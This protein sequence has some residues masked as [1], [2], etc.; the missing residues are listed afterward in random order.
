MAKYL[1]L[2]PLL[3]NITAM[4]LAIYALLNFLSAVLIFF[5]Q[6]LAAK[7]IL[8]VLGGAPFVWTGCMVFFQSILLAG[9]I[10]AH[11]LNTYAKKR[12]I[13]YVHLGLFLAAIL[14]YMPLDIKNLVMGAS[15]GSPGQLQW[16]L[17]SLLVTL[18]LPFFIISATSPLTQAWFAQTKSQWQQKPY[19]LYAASNFGS[20]I[21]LFAY[22]LLFEPFLDS[23]AQ[24]AFVDFC[25]V[26]LFVLLVTAGVTLLKS[27]TIKSKKQKAAKPIALNTKL[28]W[29]FY[30][31]IPAGLLYSVSTYI[32]TDLISMPLLWVIPLAIYILTFVLVFGEKARVIG[33]SRVIHFG[34]AAMMVLVSQT[35]VQ[36]L[37]LMLGMHFV[38]LFIFCMACHQKLYDIR[39]KNS[40]QL[41]IFYIFLS[42]GGVLG[43]L[44]NVFVA[45]HIF[46]DV[47][48]YPIFILLS[49]LIWV[50][51]KPV[52]KRNSTNI[53]FVLSILLSLVVVILA[54]HYLNFSQAVIPAT[55]VLL[56]LCLLAAFICEKRPA[57]AISAVAAV[58][59]AVKL[60][61]L[62]NGGN[63][64]Y[65]NRNIF[66]VSKVSEDVAANIR[67]FNH[68]STKHG[69]QRIV[70]ENK[71]FPTAYYYALNNYFR[72][73]PQS[74]KRKP[75]A[76]IGQGVGTLTCYGTKNQ[77][78][79]VIEINP[80]VIKIAEDYFTYMRDCPPE[81]K[82]HLGDG[83]IEMSKAED[84]KYGVIF[85][86]AFSSDSIPVHLIT[87]E[88]VQMYSTKLSHDGI[89]FFNISNRYVNLA[90]VLAAIADSSEMKAALLIYTP[91]AEAENDLAYPAIW[92]AMAHE[93]RTLDVLFKHGEDWKMLD[94]P[95]EK[96]LWRDDYSNII[97]SMIW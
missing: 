34:F 70:G 88:A 56:Y 50:N 38:G 31:L 28:T 52:W 3:S 76:I 62:L 37:N 49:L 72:H 55:V 41:T 54:T 48:E 1:D 44:F 73:L 11:V 27:P 89:I 61:A 13:V 90:P 79:D 66:G 9:Y 6:P 67:I 29:M 17:Y 64:I 30:A 36:S 65:Q 20:F 84:G 59:I 77:L 95:D 15:P 63:V 35:F 71:L 82:V 85:M 32:T 12:Q 96:F 45:P 2:R 83:R 8:P 87:R 40:G 78:V 97:N 23:K 33:S 94:K 57:M 51:K 25:F 14:I 68:G 46:S 22:P 86:D 81:K 58:T 47:S 21:G 92:V 43:G 69:I 10:Y 75:M 5:I 24:A 7:T 16:L 26:L 4:V 39:P 53:A 93:Q 80:A 91:S 60:L 18:G 19:M 42:L 74:L